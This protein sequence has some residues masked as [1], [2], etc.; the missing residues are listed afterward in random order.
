MLFI[1]CQ[2]IA[3][4]FLVSFYYLLT[5]GSEICGLG[6]AFV[7]ALFVKFFEKLH[8]NVRFACCWLLG[9]LSGFD[10]EIY[11]FL[12]SDGVY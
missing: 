4:V 12:D 8:E 9:F 2:Q 6:S 11:I 7:S 3:S 5:K 10:I 1:E